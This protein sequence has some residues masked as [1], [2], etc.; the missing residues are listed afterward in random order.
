MARETGDWLVFGLSGAIGDALRL[1][2]GPA[3][4]PLR[5]VSRVPRPEA[6]RLRWIAGALPGLADP[7]P[8]AAIASLGPLDAFSLWFEGSALR[9]A[10][11]VALG[12][13]SAATKAGSPD[14]VER[15]LARTLQAAEARLVAACAA[16]GSALTLLRP[17]LIWGRGRDRN[18]GRVVARARRWHWLPLPTGRLGRRQP[19]HADEVADAVLRALRRPLPAA[20]C[21]DL[22]GGEVLAYDEMVARCLRVAAPGARVLRVPGPLLRAGLALAGGGPGAGVLARLHQDLVFDGA[23]ARQALGWTPGP[24]RPTPADFRA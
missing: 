15:A 10:R 3:D 4:P 13:T 23:P 7:A 11:V 20:G 9:P 16:R 2:H 12:S 19:V 22:P 21:F 8:A 1:A 18:L 17:T 24:F 5:G 14:P 6:P